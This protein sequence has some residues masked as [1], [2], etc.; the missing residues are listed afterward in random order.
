MKTKRVNLPNNAKDQ[1]KIDNYLT[2][3]YNQ[4]GYFTNLQKIY[5][6]SRKTEESEAYK[7]NPTIREAVTDGYPDSTWDFFLYLTIGE[8]AAAYYLAMSF[9]DGLGAKQDEF[10]AYLSMAIGVKLGDQKSIE[11]VGS[12]SIDADVQKLADQCVVQIRKNTVGN[13]KI[14]YEQAIGRGKEVDKILIDNFKPTFENNIL[15]GSIKGYANFVALIDDNIGGPS[16][17]CFD[18][19]VHPLEQV[20]ET[21]MTG[22]DAEGSSGCCVVM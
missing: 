18:D 4:K 1:K 14:T 5:E 13:K 21:K 3:I 15:P 16:T 11:L 8:K 9:I 12:E 7:T 20:D 17:S 19:C 22:R 10:L 6:G 2:N